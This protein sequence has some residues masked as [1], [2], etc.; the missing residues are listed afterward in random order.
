MAVF[1]IGLLIA[2]LEVICWLF[3]AGLTEVELPYSVIHLWKLAL[4][5]IPVTG[6]G[7]ILLMWYRRKSESSH[8]LLGVASAAVGL[9]LS[10]FW[11]VNVVRVESVETDPGR[12]VASI[13]FL[14]ACLLLNAGIRISRSNPE[15]S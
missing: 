9:A 4:I 2:V 14:P 15:E 5:S 1:L 13:A 6:I 12:L 7:T 11:I 10:L 8:K 3:G